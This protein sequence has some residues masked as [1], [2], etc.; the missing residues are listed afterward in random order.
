MSLIDLSNNEAKT[1]YKKML[2]FD[3]IG[4]PSN[5]RWKFISKFLTRSLPVYI[6]II[7]SIPEGYINTELKVWLSVILSFCVATISSLSELTTNNE[8]G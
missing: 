3:N 4:K 2:S 7:A 6:G 8:Q 5:K 1:I